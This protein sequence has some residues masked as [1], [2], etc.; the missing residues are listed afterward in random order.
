MPKDTFYFSHDYNSRNDEKI[1]K[2]IRKH[3]MQGYGVFWAIVEELYNNANA[4]HLDYDGIAFDLRTESDVIYSVLHD[5]DLFVF[6]GDH[7]GSLS[8][9]N[10]IN[11]RKDKS[12]KARD[13]AYS[14]WNKNKNDANAL[15]TQS[16]S[17]AIKERKGK[18]IKEKERKED[19]PTIDVFLS[20]CKDD[21]IKNKLNYDLYEYSLKSKFL[22]WVENNW[23]DGNNK[24]IKSWKSKIRNTIPF[25]KPIINNHNVRPKSAHEIE[26]ETQRL[27]AANKIYE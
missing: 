25:L 10:R 4:L 11:D 12:Q 7:F 26:L 13:S 5:F 24:P 14:R 6:N 21:M 18:E 16:D 19:I 9:Q 1:K 8:V 22:S 27:K 23:K 3:G 17:N 15:Q 20:F 2:L